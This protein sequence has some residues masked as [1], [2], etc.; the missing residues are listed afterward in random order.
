[1]KDARMR[2]IYDFDPPT[3]NLNYDRGPQ[4]IRST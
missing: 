4:V 3:E 2:T 1:M